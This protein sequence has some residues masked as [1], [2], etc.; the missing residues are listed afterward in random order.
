ME[1]RSFHAIRVDQILRHVPDTTINTDCS[2]PSRYCSDAQTKADPVR[3]KRQ[4]L[5]GLHV[6]LMRSYNIQ[7]G[8]NH[9]EQIIGLR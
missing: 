7:H 9:G 8:P 1:A 2:S 6:T 3:T 5:N 4:I